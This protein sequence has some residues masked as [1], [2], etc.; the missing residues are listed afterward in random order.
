MIARLEFW[1]NS[2][3]LAWKMIIWVFSAEQCI[4]YWSINKTNL[5]KAELYKLKSISFFFS[6]LSWIWCKVWRI[7]WKH[8][9]QLKINLVIQ[10]F[11]T[12]IDVVFFNKYWPNLH[13]V[14]HSEWRLPNMWPSISV[15]C[16]CNSKSKWGMNCFIYSFWCVFGFPLL[17]Q[18]ECVTSPSIYNLIWGQAGYDSSQGLMDA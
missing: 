2:W 3:T 6:F 7:Y 15:T 18:K 14:S 16:L 9:K 10:F 8:Q 11:F 12:V 5:T 17:L 13:N 4:M 1:F